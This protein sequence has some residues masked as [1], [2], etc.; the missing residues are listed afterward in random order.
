MQK[1]IHGKKVGLKVD[2]LLLKIISY[3]ILRCVWLIFLIKIFT[4]N[5]KLTDKIFF[6]HSYIKILKHWKLFKGTKVFYLFYFLQSALKKIPNDSDNIYYIST[7]SKI[8]SYHNSFFCTIISCI[9][10]TIFH[11]YVIQLFICML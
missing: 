5:V 2:S 3:N 10:L 6:K 9:A 11:C 7:E 4:A 1:Q 8:Y